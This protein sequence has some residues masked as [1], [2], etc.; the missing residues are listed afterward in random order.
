[1]QQYAMS[2]LPVQ[3]LSFTATAKNNYAAI[4]FTTT[5]ELNTASF[6]VEKSGNG[7]SFYP[8]ASII[9]TN[10]YGNINQY[11]YT[12]ST[13]ISP[14]SYYRLKIVNVDGSF[15]YSA[16]KSVNYSVNK[17]QISVYPNPAADYVIVKM[18][19]ATAGKYQYTVTAIGG[20]VAVNNMIQLNEGAQQVKID[21]TRAGVHGLVIIRVANVQ[22]GTSESFSVIRQ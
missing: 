22:S 19:N 11:Q 10:R 21:L 5:R 9:A 4:D 3:L 16:I 12:D 7:S 17:A 18:N 6:V 8:V 1:V 13:P 14:V 20:Q 15:T 2:L